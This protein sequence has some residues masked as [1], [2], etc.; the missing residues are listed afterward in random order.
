MEK[1]K[2]FGQKACIAK[3]QNWVQSLTNK[4]RPLDKV[5]KITLFGIGVTLSLL[6]IPIIILNTVL[7]I[8]GSLDK[9]KVPTIMGIAPMVVLSDSMHHGANSITSGDMILAKQADHYKNGDVIL[10][11]SATKAWN[12]TIHRVQ[13][14]Y[15]R[16]QTTYYITKGDANNIADATPV[17]QQQVVGKYFARVPKLGQLL[18]F[19]R[20]PVGMLLSLG[21]PFMIFVLVDFI[22]DIKKT[23][24]SKKVGN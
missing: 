10:Y 13:K 16:G 2:C 21:I 7:L 18:L 22:T 3:W 14:T 24:Q 12:L 15:T 17:K 11:S 4:L 6:A 19:L 23:N 5:V 9:N 8:E 1:T 20:S